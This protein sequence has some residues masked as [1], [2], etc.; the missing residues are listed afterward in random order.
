MSTLK[1]A[2]VQMDIQWLDK[3]ANLNYL[4][5]ILDSY[6]SYDLILLP[7][8]FTTGFAIAEENIAEPEEGG[9]VLKWML[10]KS[11][12]LSSV[13]AGSVLVENKGR[14]VNRFYWVYPN[15]HVSFYDKRHLFRLGKEQDYV[16]AGHVRKVIQVND[17]RI[18]PLVCYDLRFP[19]WS[20]N[21]NDYDLIV[22]VA[23]WPSMR[24]EAWDTLL[25]ARA[26]E[27]Q[28]YVIGVNRVGNDGTNTPHSGG[29]V[30]YDYSGKLL[31]AAS[32]HESQVITADID[33]KQLAN[34][35]CKYPFFMDGDE[36]E[37]K[38]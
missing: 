26:M 2:A 15:G 38:S 17:V 6:E 9:V 16:N 4:D 7:E 36:F 31:T 8:T 34:Y 23:N 10:L 35:K 22:N 37:V 24:R 18:L 11:Q 32:D 1:V 3:K 20:R 13:I 25:R 5:S 21:R 19:V 29:T 30:I 27:N 14:K 12:M 33:L 28:A